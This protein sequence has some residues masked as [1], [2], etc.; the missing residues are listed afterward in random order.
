M[1]T[2]PRLTHKQQKI[3]DLIAEGLSNKEIARQVGIGRRTVESHRVAI[4]AKFGVKNAVQ[5]VRKHLGI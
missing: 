3:C 5:L 4:Y 1:N 2:S